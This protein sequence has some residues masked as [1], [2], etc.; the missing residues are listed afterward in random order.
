MLK[1]QTS[2]IYGKSFVS[3]TDKRPKTAGIHLIN[4]QRK[5][6]NALETPTLL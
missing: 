1:V 3:H 2:S 4:F 5:K 6:L